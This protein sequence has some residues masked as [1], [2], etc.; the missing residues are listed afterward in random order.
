VIAVV[1]R[2]NQAVRLT[3][4]IQL[5]FFHRPFDIQHE[6]AIPLHVQRLQFGGDSSLLFALNFIRMRETLARVFG[7][8]GSGNLGRCAALCGT[9]ADCAALQFLW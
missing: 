1:G 8:N 3:E 7:G 2:S 5:G 4:F 6:P 9:A